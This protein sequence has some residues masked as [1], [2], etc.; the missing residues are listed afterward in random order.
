[1]CVGCNSYVVEE[2]HD[3][4]ALVTCII[5]AAMARIVLDVQQHTVC[6]TVLLHTVM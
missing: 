2:R 5:A 6:I 1:M 4:C 3:L